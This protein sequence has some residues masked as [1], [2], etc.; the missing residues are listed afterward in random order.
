P[1]VY[2]DLKDKKTNSCP[3]CGTTFKVEKES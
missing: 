2:I 1:R 3:Y